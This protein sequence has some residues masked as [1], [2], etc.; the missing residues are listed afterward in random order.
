[1]M[2]LITTYF[3]IRD[4]TFSWMKSAMESEKREYDSIEYDSCAICSSSSL[5]ISSLH[6]ILSSSLS[7]LWKSIL[8]PIFP[9]IL[10]TAVFPTASSSSASVTFLSQMSHTF[11]NSRCFYAHVRNF[12][13][14]LQYFPKGRKRMNV[15]LIHEDDINIHQEKKK[16]WVCIIILLL[17]IIRDGN[18]WWRKV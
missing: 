9:L 16:M 12:V 8:I 2:I 13:L 15:R 4:L 11:F 3:V 17:N 5:L 10:M 7:F 1:M 18:S 14:L 6:L